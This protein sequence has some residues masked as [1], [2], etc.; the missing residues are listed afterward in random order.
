MSVS[1]CVSVSVSVCV[2]LCLCL[3]RLCLCLCLCLPV[4]LCLFHV[5]TC[6]IYL[7]CVIFFARPSQVSDRV[8]GRDLLV[9]PLTVKLPSRD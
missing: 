6:D 7:A 8:S 2:C 1:V 9:V 5:L 3:C 4:C